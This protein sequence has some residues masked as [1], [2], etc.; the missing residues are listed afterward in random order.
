MISDPLSPEEALPLLKKQSEKA[1]RLLR[2]QRSSVTWIQ[3]LSWRNTTLEILVRTF[4]EA[5]RNVQLF[6]QAKNF[7]PKNSSYPGFFFLEGSHSLLSGFIEQLEMGLLPGREE[8]EESPNRKVLIINGQ[9]EKLR[10]QVILYLQSL[11][12]EPVLIEKS[13]GAE[14]TLIDRFE[15]YSQQSAFAL[16]FL[17]GDEIGKPA[18]VTAIEPS[19][20]GTAK[21]SEM[22]RYRVAKERVEMKKRRARENE[23]FELGYF[24][25]SMGRAKVRVLSEE[26]FER[27]SDVD[28]ILYIPLDERWKERLL[29]ELRDARMVQESSDE[30]VE[31]LSKDEK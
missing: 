5:S 3:A 12:L 31:D 14:E 28:G 8:E 2:G 9:N 10:D 23:L 26:I 19:N 21:K 17:T 7:I 30:A 20:F 11:K 1:K 27:P 16:V 29:E 18:P 25:G 4:S 15:S 13:H 6:L 22:A 24:I